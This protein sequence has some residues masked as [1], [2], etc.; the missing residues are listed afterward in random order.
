MISLTNIIIGYVDQVLIWLDVTASELGALAPRTLDAFLGGVCQG[1]AISAGA[2]SKLCSDWAKLD[3]SG[4]EIGDVGHLCSFSGVFLV[5]ERGM[6]L[7][8]VPWRVGHVLWYMRI[9][10][11]SIFILLRRYRAGFSTFLEL[12]GTAK[13]FLVGGGARHY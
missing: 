1:P 12:F 8:Q 9:D 2:F 4:S 3:A 5:F 6:V 7:L 10:I 11:V 13:V